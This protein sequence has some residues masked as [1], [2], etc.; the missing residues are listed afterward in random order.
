[1]TIFEQA[2]ALIDDELLFEGEIK[3]KHATGGNS[4]RFFDLLERP[5][6]Q[7]LDLKKE[8]NQ[9]APNIDVIRKQYKELSREYERNFACANN[10]FIS[11]FMKIFNIVMENLENGD[12]DYIY[13]AKWPAMFSWI[14]N[15]ADR[16]DNNCKNEQ[17]LLRLAG[18]YMTKVAEPALRTF[19]TNYIKSAHGKHGVK[20]RSDARADVRSLLD[21]TSFQELLR[22]RSEGRF[23]ITK[24]SSHRPPVIVDNEKRLILNFRNFEE[25]NDILAA[26]DEN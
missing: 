15:N 11:G 24:G 20:S 8:R 14:K 17:A 18:E 7:I 25:L 6:K 10:R 4:D 2:A 9:E 13:A 19:K 22:T 26:K 21:D 3:K 12:T 5:A 16:I 23:D 1:M